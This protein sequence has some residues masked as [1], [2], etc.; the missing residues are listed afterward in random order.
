MSRTKLPLTDPDLYQ[1]GVPYEYFRWL[2]D[3][4]PVSWHDESGGA[5]YWA[6]SR[7]DDVVAAKCPI[8]I[9]DRH[10]ALFG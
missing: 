2:R 10:A 3:H 6:I 4:E 7:Y 1:A 9:F 8:H 5:G